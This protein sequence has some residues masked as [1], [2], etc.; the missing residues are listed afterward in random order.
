MA[1]LA[2]AGVL[3]FVELD[4][5]AMALRS[6]DMLPKAWIP[7]LTVVVPT[8]EVLLAGTYFLRLGSRWVWCLCAVLL[9][10]LYTGSLAL[11]SVLSSP[12]D[13][14]CLGLLMA[15]SETMKSIQAAFIRNAIMIGLLGGG[16]VL[17]RCG[18]KV[19][20]R[21]V[22]ASGPGEGAV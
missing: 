11:Q 9:L 16:M 17:H 13:C 12:P 19:P 5:F 3:K 21:V 20:G 18:G 22:R 15:H 1:S 4:R 10:V 8:S 7:L 2:L 6:W 14:D